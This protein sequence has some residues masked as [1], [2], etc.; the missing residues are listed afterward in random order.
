VIEVLNLYTQ[1]S[2]VERFKNTL[3]LFSYLRNVGLKASREKKVNFWMNQNLADRQDDPEIELYFQ[4]EMDA[5]SYPIELIDKI[6]SANSS[7]N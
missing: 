1:F 2:K 3:K 4:H 7:Q 5:E 6:L